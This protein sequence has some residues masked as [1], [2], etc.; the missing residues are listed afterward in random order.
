M[1][2]IKS[3]IKL[4][5]YLCLIF[6]NIYLVAYESI[7]KFVSHLIMIEVTTEESDT[8]LA[9]AITVGRLGPTDDA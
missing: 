6:A 3:F 7:T 8:L 1:N 5:C 9:P 2:C 4:F